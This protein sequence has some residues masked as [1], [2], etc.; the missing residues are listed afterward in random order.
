MNAV[1]TSFQF[2]QQTESFGD[3]I[4]RE[5]IAVL[6]FGLGFSIVVA[7]VILLVDPSF[8]Y[9]R[10]QT[11]ALLYYLKGKTFAETGSTAARLAVNLPPFPYA[12]LPG[13]LRSPLIRAF[14]DFDDQLRAIQ[15]T[16]ILVLD[17]IA[18]MSAYIFSWSL[19]KE[20]HWIAI[21]FA[22]AFT[23]VS[24]WW[25]ANVFLALADAPYAAAFL[26]SMLVAV[27]ITVSEKPFSTHGKAAVVFGL[28]FVVGFS[29]RY[30]EPAVL[31]LAAILMKGRVG[32][33][34]ISMRFSVGA[35]LL[36]LTAI[37]VL[38]FFN[39]EA[40]FERYLMEPI[41]FVQKGEKQEIIINLFSL[42][43]PEQII[44]G[45]ALG[46][47]RPP[48]IDLYHAQFATTRGDIAWSVV[49]AFIS[50]G[51]V[52][53]AWASRERFMPELV[54]FLV[55]LPVLGVVMASTSRYLMTYQAFFWIWFYEGARLA[56]RRI[57]TSVRRRLVSSAGIFAT[58]AIV[59]GLAVGIRSRRATSGESGRSISQV[60]RGASAYV[61]DITSTFKPLRKFLLAL[62]H[63]RAILTASSSPGRW[64]AIANL[65]YYAADSGLVGLASRKDVY[66]V[67]ECGSVDV[68]AGMDAR[69][70][71]IKEGLCS[72][73]E[74]NYQ[75]VFEAHARR[76]GARVY[77]VRP[78]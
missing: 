21:G 28:L 10:L 6:A 16:N 36:A 47:S 14:P 27:H 53:G 29:L 19:P 62:P 60:I 46:F 38:V 71:R 15:L 7:A 64:N 3:F 70:A 33:S 8:F 20:R 63:D 67:I 13:V 57:P 74:F 5:K 75:L 51:V 39:R 50:A 49:G 34:R 65:D 40:I 76:S 56:A 32:D 30:T 43:I 17:A 11:D 59:A 24:P 4:R 9:S 66:F 69:E 26:A 25:M 2:H 31:V 61:D 68:C 45:F 54:L 18:L 58:L 78:A 55:V 23:V 35:A 77:R 52:W 42:A 37:G 1:E 48:M 22:F 41:S 72:I 73:G 12:S 44:P